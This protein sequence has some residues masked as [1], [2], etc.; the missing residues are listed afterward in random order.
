MEL[1]EY[2]GR[3]W[4]RKWI[5]VGITILAVLI[6]IAVLYSLPRKYVATAVVEVGGLQS[7]LGNPGQDRDFRQTTPAAIQATTQKYLLL[8]ESPAIGD[9]ARSRMDSRAQDGSGIENTLDGDAGARTANAASE[10]FDY[11]GRGEAVRGSSAD[12]LFIDVKSGDPKL[13][14]EAADMLALVLIEQSRETA[15]DVAEQYVSSIKE[16]KIDP[17]DEQLAEIR[18][19]SETLKLMTG[20]N[21]AERNVQI[22][23]LADE[24]KVL[25]DTRKSYSELV[26]RVEIN[27]TLNNNDLSILAEA[28]QP[29]SREKPGYLRSGVVAAVVGLLVGV[30]AVMVFDRR[31]SLEPATTF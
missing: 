27:E 24:A 22:A 20:G 17:I 10:E 25:D 30:M 12:L 4:R 18:K 9:T 31:K 29:F 14:K 23:T 7:L 5:V 11:A 19:E 3:L 8:L 13:A 16:T 28:A 15:K 21:V 1:S 2:L 26:A 6:D